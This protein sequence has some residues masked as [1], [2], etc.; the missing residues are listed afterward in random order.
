MER[1]ARHS[2]AILSNRWPG[3]SAGLDSAA[4]SFGYVAHWSAGDP[5]AVRDTAE[6][7]AATARALL[8]ACGFAQ[9]E[10]VREPMAA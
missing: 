7:V 8:H 2:R 5:K 4:Y 3:P 1:T 9:P 10:A 6:G